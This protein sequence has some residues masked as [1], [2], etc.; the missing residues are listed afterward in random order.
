MLCLA[1]LE[2]TCLN[3]GCGTHLTAGMYSEIIKT[4]GLEDNEEVT[5]DGQLTNFY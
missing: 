5:G 1:E 2:S 3:E 4:G